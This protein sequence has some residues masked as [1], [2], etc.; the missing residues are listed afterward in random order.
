MGFPILVRC[1]LYI[2]SGTWTFIGQDKDLVSIQR[3]TITWTNDLLSETPLA[4]GMGEI[5]LL[6]KNH[7]VVFSRPID[8]FHKC[9][10]PFRKISHNVPICNRNAHRCPHF[11]Y[12]VVH[13]GIWGWC[14]VG[15]FRWICWLLRKLP[16][17]FW[18]WSNWVESKLYAKRSMTFSHTTELLVY[19]FKF[20]TVCILNCPWIH[21][22]IS[23]NIFDEVIQW[24]LSIAT[25]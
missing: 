17:K 20:S 4:T 6:Q 7:F 22:T 1:H 3:D 23:C 11:C 8:S 12:K 25:T 10:N 14:F 9:H 2:E 19:Q 18:Y 21:R 15:Y 24:N 16:F 13:C 5:K